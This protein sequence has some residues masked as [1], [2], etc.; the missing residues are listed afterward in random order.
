MLCW[1]FY[2]SIQ[3]ST[4]SQT[5]SKAP[6]PA[7]AGSWFD[8]VQPAPSVLLFPGTRHLTG[9][10]VHCLDLHLIHLFLEPI[11]CFPR[12][13]LG[14]IFPLLNTSSLYFPYVAIQAQSKTWVWQ[15]NQDVMGFSLVLKDKG[16]LSSEEQRF[17]GTKPAFFNKK[18]CRVDTALSGFIQPEAMKAQIYVLKQREDSES[19]HH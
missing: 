1:T 18:G 2:F 8:S 4:S 13:V 12:C 5:R 7:T 17:I 15:S 9:R 10:C 11:G 19:F 3:K 16:M 6:T 14:Y